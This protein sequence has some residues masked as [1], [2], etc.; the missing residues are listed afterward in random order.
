MEAGARLTVVRNVKTDPIEYLF[1][2]ERID[3][4]QKQAADKFMALWERAAFGGAK[5]IDYSQPKVDTSGPRSAV[6][7]ASID[8]QSELGHA[9]RVV[10]QT[11]WHIVTEICGRR[12][13]IEAVARKY[14]DGSSGAKYLVSTRLKEI[15]DELAA[16]WGY[17]SRP[18][19]PPA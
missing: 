7:A 13:T 8:A 4:P 14:Y 12:E 2:R 5:A 1:A 3:Q 16:H 15:L 19:R 11:G 6:P 9:R 18:N 17:A 10:D